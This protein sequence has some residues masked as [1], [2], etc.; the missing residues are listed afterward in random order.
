MKIKRY[1]PNFVDIE[2]FRL[3]EAMPITIEDLLEVSWVKLWSD[4]KGFYRFSLSGN[5][6][7]A[8]L[9][10]GKEWWIVGIFEDKSFQELPEWEPK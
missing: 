8:E 3:E 4:V 5:Y 6:L 7:M 2:G 9:H 10:E 1:L